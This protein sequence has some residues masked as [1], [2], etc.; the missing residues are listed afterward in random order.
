MRPLFKVAITLAAAGTISCG[1]SSSGDPSTMP[2]NDPFEETAN[3]TESTTDG[4]DFDALYAR[5]GLILGQD[6]QDLLERDPDAYDQI[7]PGSQQPKD[8]EACMD[9]ARSALS[10]R[11]SIEIF[12]NG[13]DI[14]YGLCFGETGN[15]EACRLK[16]WLGQLP[17]WTG[18]ATSEEDWQR[19]VQ[20][21]ID[22][23]CEYGDQASCT[24]LESGVGPEGRTW[25]PRALE[26]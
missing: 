6:A 5:C 12:V 9:Y 25:A 11:P 15:G 18:E 8:V 23:G 4:P 26:N 16:A 21:W 17:Y 24:I 1:G 20:Q 19:D 7:D 14:A 22:M 13:S 10:L 2:A 3:T